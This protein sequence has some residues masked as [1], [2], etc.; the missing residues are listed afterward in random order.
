MKKY[1]T[2]ILLLICCIATHSQ[3]QVH[4]IKIIDTV[5]LNGYLLYEGE[6][7]M[8]MCGNEA[9]P[10]PPV[11]F[12]SEQQFPKAIKK[13]STVKR[14]RKRRE[15]EILAPDFVNTPFIYDSSE[16]VFKKD[17]ILC[18]QPV[19]YGSIWT[20][21]NIVYRNSHVKVRA[22]RIAT[23]FYRISVLD[24]SLYARRHKLRYRTCLA[25]Y[26]YKYNNRNWIA[27]PDKTTR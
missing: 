4:Y 2:Y 6:W 8:T 20:D 18:N 14:L 5:S 3:A 7:K 23:L 26:C 12:V 22:T 27:L 10:S 16:V 17:T 21:S 1:T 11:Y 13:Y 9:P 24:K 15:N 25:Y 19:D